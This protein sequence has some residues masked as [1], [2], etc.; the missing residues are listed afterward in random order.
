[1]LL[2]L[3]VFFPFLKTHRI[4]A[5]GSAALNMAYVALG[6]A[7]LNFEFGIHV[8]DI[9]KIFVTKISGRKMIIEKIK[10]VLNSCCFSGW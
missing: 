7:D 2:H 1:M 9:G 4:R 3:I 8:W 6:S 10:C 5:I